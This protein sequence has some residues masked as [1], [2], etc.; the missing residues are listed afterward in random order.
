MA[1]ANNLKM[2]DTWIGNFLSPRRKVAKFTEEKYNLLRMTVLL[3][4]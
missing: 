1:Y 3:K 2:E 4:V